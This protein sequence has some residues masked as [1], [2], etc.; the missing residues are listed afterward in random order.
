MDKNKNTNKMKLLQFCS[1]Q[2]PETVLHSF[3]TRVYINNKAKKIKKQM[4]IQWLVLET[5]FFVR[6]TTTVA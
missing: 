3:K 2:I 1:F 4:N 6:Y 5:D